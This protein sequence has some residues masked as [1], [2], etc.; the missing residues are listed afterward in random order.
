MPVRAGGARSG[1]WCLPITKF[2]RDHVY[3]FD[4]ELLDGN[5]EL[6][7]LSKLAGKPVWLNFFTSWCGPCNREAADIVSI[8]R[9]YG[10][11]VH[12]VGIDVAEKPE[13][14]RAF[15]DKHAIPFPI[16]LDTTS[17]VFDALGFTGYPTHAFLDQQ[18]L[19]SCLSAGDLTPTQMDNELAVALARVPRPPPTTSAVVKPS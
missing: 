6:F 15:R 4:L 12:V 13:Q 3:D 14:A 17:S 2:A 10:D 7:S 16:A 9:K 19:I 18:G 11:A 5:G 8:W 1:Q